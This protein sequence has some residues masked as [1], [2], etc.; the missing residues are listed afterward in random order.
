MKILLL[1]GY[2]ITLINYVYG[3][4]NLQPSSGPEPVP[5]IPSKF[6]VRV[7]VNTEGDL[8]MSEMRYY[9]DYDQ[10]KAAIETRQNNMNTRLIFNYQTDEIYELTNK[11][12]ILTDPL[13]W[14]PDGRPEFPT[15]C[16]TYKLTNSSLL[17]YYFGFS[18]VDNLL[19]PGPAAQVF[20]FNPITYAGESDVRGIPCEI[21][22]SCGYDP[23]EN[24]NFTINHF[25]SKTGF[26]M[27]GADRI[28]NRIPLRA[29]YEKTITQ[30]GGQTTKQ[31]TYF[32]YH[33]F[34]IFVERPEVFQTPSGVFCQ[35]RKATKPAPP[36]MLAFGFSQE[37]TSN[38]EIQYVK[39]FYTFAN[40]S[41]YEIRNPRKEES[42]FYTL[43][44]VLY[45]SELTIGIQYGINQRH[46]NCSVRGIKSDSLYSPKLNTS[47]N[48]LLAFLAQI[49]S[50]QTFLSY[51]SEF[52][53]TG[54]RES[55]GI[56]ADRF[57]TQKNSGIY[58]YTF[59]NENILILND[60]E[61]E[62]NVPISLYID[63][64]NNN[65]NSHSSFYN[66]ETLPPTNLLSLFDISSCFDLN[67]TIEFD[68]IFPYRAIV[69]ADDVASVKELEIVAY[70]ILTSLTNEAA[71]RFKTPRSSIS[72]DGNLYIRTAIFPLPPPITFF[73]LIEK[74]LLLVPSINTYPNVATPNDCARY[75]INN[76]KC[77]SFDYSTGKV[78]HLNN[79]TVTDGTPS[80]STYY[81]HYTRNVPEQRTYL[82]SLELFNLVNNLVLDGK[83]IIDVPTKDENNQLVLKELKAKE[84][85]ERRDRFDRF[86]TTNLLSK[87]KLIQP[88]TKFLTSQEIELSGITIDDCAKACNEQV[89]F[90]CNT[91]DYCF[92]TGDCRLRKF[93][94]SENASQYAVDLNCDV[95]EKDA[96]SHY[97]RFRGKVSVNPKDLKYVKIN[98]PTECAKK[99]DK[100][101]KINCKS[102][103]F[104]PLTSACFLSASHFTDS[105][106]IL[107]ENSTC[108]H[109]SRKFLSDFSYI[110]ES[111]IKAIGEF[112]LN[113][114]NLEACSAFCVNAD[115]INCKS[116]DYCKS[117]R[118]CIINS[119]N[120]NVIPNPNVLTEKC[121]H[122]RREY[123]YQTNQY[124]NSKRI[125]SGNKGW[126]I[127]LSIAFGCI[128]KWDE[129][130]DFGVN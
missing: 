27:A 74:K 5:S 99:C 55:N 61:T 114:A 111:E 9:Y 24:S 6:Q 69:T 3:Q 32:D 19:L 119:G 80:T 127:G 40:F 57:I 76:P 46:G 25:F 98:D 58:E 28:F 110:G 125:E 130:K 129:P 4:C 107:S 83:V 12:E 84:V 53:Y 21:Y 29:V 102:F 15:T 34:K 45:I 79:R 67:T 41:R 103:N 44:P 62:K 17:N 66:F 97:D 89:G 91:F 93:T 14:P 52:I 59:S 92:P 118:T 77:L 120:I 81:E 88:K 56:S 115:G 73:T 104:C 22:R 1:L 37:I 106:S 122:Y 47:Y 16:N 23:A 65:F 30:S 64:P 8:K 70:S 43:D 42:T 49:Q 121:G 117:S 68:I 113:D 26:N 51:D 108:D 90:D 109:Y 11:I 35:D 48:S 128:V 75:C 94:Q 87:Y 100:E 86:G 7:E 2:L 38:S 18:Q 60:F 33:D 96:L 126:L 95:Y 20:G 39:D 72:T 112:V 63:N 124:F 13:H 10:R 116:F 123:F 50:T 82:D 36:I 105:S 101:S 54:K 78:C 85:I 31:F 71:L